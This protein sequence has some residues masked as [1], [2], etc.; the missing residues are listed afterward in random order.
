LQVCH[1]VES[2]YALSIFLLMLF[3][4]FVSHS[5]IFYL[6]QEERNVIFGAYQKFGLLCNKK[7][8]SKELG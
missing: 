1:I 6:I 3:T 7:N 8:G 2:N 5:I 4:E